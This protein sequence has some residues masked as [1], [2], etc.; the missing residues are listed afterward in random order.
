MLCLVSLTRK[1]SDIS[2]LLNI[3]KLYRIEESEKMADWKA[4]YAVSG[5]DA[6]SSFEQTLVD[7]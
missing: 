7:V 3:P 6:D 5:L 1:I 2:A 4:N